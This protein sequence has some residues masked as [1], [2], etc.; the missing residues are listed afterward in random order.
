MGDINGHVEAISGDTY[1]F[2]TKG[3]GEKLEEDF[4]KDLETGGVRE[5]TEGVGD[6]GY[7]ELH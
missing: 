6:P 4:G 7:K 1:G 2:F 5:C 3:E